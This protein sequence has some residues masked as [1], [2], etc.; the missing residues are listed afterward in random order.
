MTRRLL[1]LATVAMLGLSACSDPRVEPLGEVAAELRA[2]RTQLRTNVG[3]NEVDRAQVA[4]ALA[5]LRTAL[6]G[7]LATQRDLQTRQIELTREMQ[8]WSAL[9]TDSVATAR[10]K[11]SEALQTRLQELERN[12]AAQDVRHREVEAI[13]QGALDHT[14]DRLESFLLRLEGK[15]PAPAADGVAPAPGA[16]P[17]KASEPK[18]NAA[19]AA[20]GK[21]DRQAR[22]TSGW[23]WFCLLTASVG[24]GGMLFH[25]ARRA[26]ASLPKLMTP[27]SA[28]PGAT[29]AT[30]AGDGD[31][32]ST[33]EIWAAA[34]LLGEAVDRLRNQQSSPA[35]SGSASASESAAALGSSAVGATEDEEVYVVDGLDD[36]GLDDDEG[37]SSELTS[38]SP[39]LPATKLPGRGQPLRVTCRLRPR[40]VTT[41]SHVVLA[42]LKADPRVLRR[43]EPSLHDTA[44]ELLVSFA[45]VPGLPAGERSVLEQRLRDCVA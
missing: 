45:L 12:L 33:E 20:N 9:L 41:A 26:G 11:E 13:L 1:A 34:A 17:P 29:Q 25:R 22:T 8:Q 28:L 31:E 21:R 7:L 16:T 14:A 35:A 27:T 3:T 36:E 15:S 30:R 2:L 24:V 32:R 6:D 43:P 40:D 39:A 19:G 5:P 42:L 10:R 44:G 37:P 38:L 4:E 18:E 23:L